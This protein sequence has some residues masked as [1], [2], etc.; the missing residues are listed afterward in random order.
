VKEQE[1]KQAAEQITAEAAIV[2]HN[3]RY[4][5]ALAMFDKALA[6]D[7]GNVR[8]R[9]GRSL[10]LTQLGRAVE[11]LEAAQEA[12]RGDP[13]YAPSYTA[14]AYAYHRLGRNDEAEKAFEAAIRLNPTGADAGRVLYNYA[15]YWAERR[16]EEK[17]RSYLA[18]ALEFVEDHTLDHAPNDPDLARYVAT[19]WFREMLAAAKKA[20]LR[21]KSR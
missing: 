3:G 6:L 18:R 12:V 4:A 19:E 13:S 8:A 1:K 7:A 10:A 17:C 21:A 15:C 20:R 9:G 2:F 16:D 14:L 5:A 11:A